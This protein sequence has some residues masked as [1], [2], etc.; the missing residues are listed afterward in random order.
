MK[1]E[2]MFWENI[3]G[4][5]SM[6]VFG[7]ATSSCENSNHSFRELYETGTATPPLNTVKSDSVES[8]KSAVSLINH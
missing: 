4:G 2:C 8:F 6:S 3:N 7:I 5:M 1:S